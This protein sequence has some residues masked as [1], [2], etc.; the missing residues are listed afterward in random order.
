MGFSA[1]AAH[2]SDASGAAMGGAGVQG[3]LRSAHSR[4]PAPDLDP[5]AADRESAPSQEDLVRDP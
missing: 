4:R 1:Q 2:R 5:S 3:P